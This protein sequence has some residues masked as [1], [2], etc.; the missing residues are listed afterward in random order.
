LRGGHPGLILAWSVAIAAAVGVRLWNALAG[1]LMWGYDAWGHVAYALF[2]DL[3]RGLPWADQGWSYFHPPLHYA[4]GWGLAQFG[5]GEFLMR[6]LAVL[7]GAASLATAFLAGWLVRQVSPERPALALVGFAAVAF[8]PVHLFVGGMPGNEM[9]LTLLCAA[10]LCVFIANDRRPAPTW[11]GDAAAG[12]LAGLALLTKFSGLLPLLT[13]CATLALRAGRA[14]DG[15]R[16]VGRALARGALLT[17]VA[18]LIAAPYYAR[19]VRHFG[20]PFELSRGY[21]LVAEVE[22]DQRPGAR[23]WLDYVRL[24]FGLLVDADPRAPHMLHSVWG[25]A[26]ADAWADV[27]RESDVERALASHASARAMVVAGLLPSALAAAGAVLALRDSRRG[28]RRAVYATLWVHAV[29]TLLAFALFSWRV[30]IWSALKASYLL[31]LSLPFGVFLARGVE[32]VAERSQPLRVASFTALAAI[33]VASCAVGLS[34]V[35]RPR[36][37]D[38]PAAAAVHFYFAEYDDARRIY[39]RLVSGSAYPVPW[40]DN[41]AAVELASGR[42][43][44]SRRLYA[45]AVA[46]ERAANRENGYRRGQLAVAQ[47]LA[48]ESDAALAELDAAL[49]AEELPELRANRGAIR[50]ARGDWVGAESDLRRALDA[51]GA[52]VP[53]WLNLAVVQARAG[54]PEAAESRTR[55]ARQACTPPRRFPYGVGTGEVLEWGVGRRWL[56]L[57][58]DGGLRVALP[59]FYRRAC[60]RLGAAG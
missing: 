51:D 2:L 35:L 23:G 36:R 47:A 21:P 39:G 31:G 25:T 9:T 37:A 12:A 19:N 33:A 42:P 28:R 4:L 20:T 14:R 27:F 43:E 17:G 7:G 46:I 6:G 54:R 38:A 13:V 10:S 58:E 26:Y 5:R 29:V 45:R 24:P 44:R 57:L 53:A 60:A 49:D 55:A 32:A 8:L 41:L 30:P 40:L 34:G 3:Y 11:Q 1:P 18:L 15:A 22:R 50:A 48:G 16:G 56:L 59:E 52:L